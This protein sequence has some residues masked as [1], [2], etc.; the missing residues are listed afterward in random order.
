VYQMRRFSRLSHTVTA[1]NV[2]AARSW[3]ACAEQRP[4][5]HVRG[6]HAGRRRRAPSGMKYAGGT[7]VSAVASHWTVP[8]ALRR[9]LNSSCKDVAAEAR[10]RRRACRR[11]TSRTPSPRRSRANEIVLRLPTDDRE[12]AA[13][14][15]RRRWLAGA[16]PSPSAARR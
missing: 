2:S 7:S 16:G 4:E 12:E 1:S 6:P 13:D 14:A 8:S 9:A 3:F 15:H 5:V 10:R 11:R